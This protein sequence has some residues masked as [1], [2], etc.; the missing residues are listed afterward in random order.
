VDTTAL[1]LGALAVVLIAG[2][3]VR[4]AAAAD[5]LMP[6]RVLRSRS[7]VGGNLVQMLMIS[8]MFAFQIVV[9]LTMQQVLGYGPATTGLAML[10]AAVSIG[11]TALAIAPRLIARLGERT[12]LLAGLT[13]LTG[14]LALLLRMPSHAAYAAD[15]LPTMLLISGGGLAM[16]AAA[17]LGMSGAREQD[18]GVIS[19]L[20]NTTAQIGSSLGA[21]VLTTLAAAHSGS[22]LAGGRSPAEALLGGYRLAFAVGVGLLLA[23]LLAAVLLL[24]PAPRQE[25]AATRSA[26]AGW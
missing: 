1:G 19:G 17:A 2:F 21:A 20:Y 13:M 5:P 7:V 25:R 11:G 12:V 4:Q 10:P 14:A 24:R 22:L 3:F 9:S 6:L 15:L 26:R 18:A 8:A 16:P 23:A